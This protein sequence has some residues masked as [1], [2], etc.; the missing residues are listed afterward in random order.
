MLITALDLKTP[1]RE[2]ELETTSEV[3]ASSELASEL[4][5]AFGGKDNISSLDACITR[6]RVS[7]VDTARV[8]TER[9]KQLGATAV[10]VVGN[11]MQAIF[12]PRSDNI[13]SEMAEA[14]KK[15]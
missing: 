10:M 7:V 9:V 2:D 6:L 14:M 11:N 15:M 12:G 4:I 5:K 1:G 3:A 13:R 8:D